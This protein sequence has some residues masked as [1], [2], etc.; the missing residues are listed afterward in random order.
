MLYDKNI[1]AFKEF[2]INKRTGLPTSDFQV[3]FP[4]RQLQAIEAYE[5]LVKVKG[6]KIDKIEKESLEKIKSNI[7]QLI[8]DAL[9]QEK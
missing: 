1:P 6:I 7:N 9:S 5:K 3:L 8:K 2:I 4:K